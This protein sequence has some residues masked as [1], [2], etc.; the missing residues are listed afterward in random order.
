M[1]ISFTG[2]AFRSAG[3]LI[4]Q[5]VVD[6]RVVS[7]IVTSDA[8]ALWSCGYQHVSAEDVYLLHRDL[9]EQ[10]ASEL[11]RA[12]GQAPI[13]VRGRALVAL[14]TSPSHRTHGTAT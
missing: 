7:C 4:I 3:D 11:I 12:G 6:N 9:I 1:N 5:A 14:I 13:I 10:V 2:K 8:L